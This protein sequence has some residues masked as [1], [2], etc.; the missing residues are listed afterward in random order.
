MNR[1]ERRA[2]ERATPKGPPVRS[3]APSLEC[4]RCHF[5][6]T[7]TDLAREWDLGLEIACPKCGGREW[8]VSGD[9]GATLRFGPVLYPPRRRPSRREADTGTS[10]S[11]NTAPTDGSRPVELVFEVVPVSDETASRMA[12]SEIGTSLFV[13]CVVCGAPVLRTDAFR[14]PE[15]HAFGALRGLEAYTCSTDRCDCPECRP[16]PT[17]K[18]R[19]GRRGP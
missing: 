18:A 2:L 10:V 9:P 13:R 8:E 19:G 15:A 14:L 16:A 7:G 5:L 11:S 4:A 3:R 12:P 1:S 6:L 17:G